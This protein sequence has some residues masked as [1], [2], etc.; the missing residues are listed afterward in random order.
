MEL[1]AELAKWLNTTAPN[2]IPLPSSTS[3]STTTATATPPVVSV[4][5]GA[6]LHAARTLSGVSSLYAAVEKLGLL[7]KQ[8]QGLNTV[9]TSMERLKSN[10][11]HRLYLLSSGNRVL[12]LIKMGEKK[13][14][15]RPPN[16]PAVLQEIEP[17]CC[18]D[19]YVV[20][21]EQRSGWGIR[22]YQAML[23]AEGTEP[24]LV[25]I[26]RPSPKF[27]SFLRKH[28][29]LSDYTQQ[30]NHFV[31]FHQ[32]WAGKGPSSSTS[33]SAQSSQQK[34][35]EQGL[36]TTGGGGGR[37]GLATVPDVNRWTTSTAAA[38]FVQ[39]SSSGGSPRRQQQ[40]ASLQPPL[41]SSSKLMTMDS[42]GGHRG[43]GGRRASP[44]RGS[45]VEYNIITGLK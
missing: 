38:S 28:F 15:V 13:L 9:L 2:R 44:V 6:S 12:G 23:A 20:E 3:G 33:S 29:S 17:L 8:S 7:S 25:A 31:V 34:H 26:D 27:L 18:L 36:T 10:P 1:S 42:V 40:Q 4:W 30:T 16:N 35:H 5:T 22:L 14:F 19:F 37:G 41:S 45:A 24:R 39:S 11:T 21:S 32:Y 43:G